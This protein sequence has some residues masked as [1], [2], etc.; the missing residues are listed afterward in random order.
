MS[1]PGMWRRVDLVRTYVSEELT[2]S[3][4]RVKIMSESG[5]TLAVTTNLARCLLH[6]LVTV[7]FIPSS[8]II[9]ILKMRAIRS[10]EASILM[11]A[12]RRHIPDDGILQ[13]NIRFTYF[14]LSGHDRLPGC[15]Q[16]Y[17]TADSAF[18]KVMDTTVAP[19]KA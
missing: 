4:I 19:Q 6:A 11:K 10:S 15:L 14:S 7:N 1:V 8:L 16:Y 12:T 3:I 17:F 18:L 2:A 13:G 5:I 9:F